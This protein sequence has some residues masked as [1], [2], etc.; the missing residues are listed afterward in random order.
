MF[1]AVIVFIIIIVNKG[2]HE[3]YD[4]YRFHIMSLVLKKKFFIGIMIK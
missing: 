4:M 3:N 1:S 2:N